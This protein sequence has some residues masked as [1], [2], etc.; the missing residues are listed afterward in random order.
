MALEPITRQEKII[1]GQDLEPITRMEM[2]LKQFGGGGGSVPKPLTYDYMPEGYPSKAMGTVALMEEQ[3]LEF[4]SIDSGIYFASLISPLEIVEGQT[5]TVKWDG[6]EYECVCVIIQSASV[7]GN[8][9]IMGAGN[10]TGEPFLCTVNNREAITEFYTLDT[11]ASHTI[12]VKRTEEIVTPMAEEFLPATAL[13]TYNLGTNTYSSDLT[14]DELYAKLLDGKQIVLYK[15]DGNEY[16][17]LTKWNKR[18][19]GR[20]DLAFAGEDYSVS[21][22]TDG[23]IGK[24]PLE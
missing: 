20:I 6:S 24:K 13:I 5:Y 16:L 3:G 15:T 18:S 21:L 14:N 2:F 9:S 12:S 7:I 10:D 17:Y 22:K 1:A 11:S 23:T 8:L 19:S 4:A